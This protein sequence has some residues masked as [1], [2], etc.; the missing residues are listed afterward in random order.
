MIIRV[1]RAGR[2][3]GEIGRVHICR[4]GDGSA[5]FHIWFMARPARLPQTVGSFA[6]IWDG[7]LPPLPDDVWRANL[8]RVA[9][10]MESALAG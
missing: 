2:S 10:E 8:E 1:E 9:K 7:I 3:V 6:A 5:H 4:W